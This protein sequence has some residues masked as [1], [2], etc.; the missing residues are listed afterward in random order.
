MK[1]SI[2]SLLLFAT[3]FIG[4][5]KDDDEDNNNEETPNYIVFNDDNFKRILVADT[6]LNTNYDNEITEE[7][8]AAFTGHI[9]AP[10]EGLTDVSELTYFPNITGISLYGND[11]TSID[12]S[13]NTKVVQLLLEDNQLT[14]VDVSALSVLTDFKCHSN[15]LVEAN[16][17]NG[18]NSNM[19]RVQF[20]A[21]PDLTCITVDDLA[22]INT[23]WIKDNTA[24]YSTNCN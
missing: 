8:A 7:E 18:N 2:L 13:H 9:L 5:S 6:A 21:N 23:N 24:G 11:L 16:V 4:C 12:V 17:A 15:K 14:S 1:K 10:N 22:D 3:I 19:T 20:H